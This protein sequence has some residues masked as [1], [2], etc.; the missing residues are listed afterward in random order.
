MGGKAHRVLLC[1][2]E[3]CL[4]VVFFPQIKKRSMK[5]GENGDLEV[6]GNK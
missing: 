4:V 5:G 1:F 3:G 2:K 6:I